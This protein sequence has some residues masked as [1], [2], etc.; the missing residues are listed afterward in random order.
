[1]WRRL[2]EPCSR[3][4]RGQWGGGPQP[5][6]CTNATHSAGFP[7]LWLWPLPLKVCSELTFRPSWFFLY[8]HWKLWVLSASER[9]GLKSWL[10]RNHQVRGKS[11]TPVFLI[12]E[13]VWL[14]GAL[15]QGVKW[16]P[17]FSPLLAL[18]VA[19]PE[20]LQ[21]TLQLWSSVYWKTQLSDTALL[22]FL[23]PLIPGISS[24]NVLGLANRKYLLQENLPSA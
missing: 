21:V 17:V 11:T 6:R 13:T 2:T 12:S 1:M 15:A 22:N 5:C 7:S 23:E 16:H 19:F 4:R 9:T 10:R 8:D 3:W 18:N 24:V 20:R 14:A